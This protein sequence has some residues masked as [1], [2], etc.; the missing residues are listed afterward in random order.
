MAVFNAT[1]R[2]DEGFEL[3]DSFSKRWPGYD[4][5]K[6]RERWEAYKRSPPDRIGAGTIFYMADAATPGWREEYE[7][8]TGRMGVTLND[9][10]AYMPMHNYIFMPTREPWPA[11]SADARLRPVSLLGPDRKPTKVRASE[12]LDRNRPVEQMTWA[13]GLPELIRDR[14]VAEGGL[15]ERPGAACLNLYRAPTIVPGYAAK[16]GPWLEHVRKVYPNDAKHIVEWLAHRV[17]RPQE[18]IN[19][20]LVLG[21]NQGIGKDTLLEPVKR[22]VGPWNFAEVTPTQMTGRF[23]GFVKSVILRVSEARDLGEGN[24]YQF[25]E[26]LKSYTAAPPDVLRVDEKNLREHSVMNCTG[27]I[28]TTNHKTDGIYL[29]ADDRR[30]YV[31]WSDL[32]K[33]DFDEEYWRA[34]WGWY[35]DGGD[36]HVAAYLA[37]LDISSFNPKAPPPKTAAFWAIV[38]ANR[39][40]VDAELADVLDGLGNPD[41]VTLSDI[42]EMA[43]QQNGYG[44]SFFEWIT[45]RRNRRA[46]PY[47]LEQ[48]G[49]VPVRNPSTQTGLWVVGGARQV[50]YAKAGLSLADQLRAAEE[51]TRTGTRAPKTEFEIVA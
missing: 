22:A 40:P 27:V 3:F 15:I 20:A 14:L 47:R 31:A 46:I 35:D 8:K 11:R 42:S 9:F 48:C 4:G 16:A 18:K 39:A 5:A 19:H 32:E 12:W 23:N 45:D 24:R 51:R 13:P 43:A 25:Y 41:A 10:Y 26:H 17:Q 37:E 38:D 44:G 28:L 1:G 6:T 29:P 7:K 34:L 33:E 30:H 2:S 49:Y 21:G 50:I 36:R